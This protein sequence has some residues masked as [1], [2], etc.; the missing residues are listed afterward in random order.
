MHFMTFNEAYDMIMNNEEIEY[1]RRDLNFSDNERREVRN[2]YKEAIRGNKNYYFYGEP[3]KCLLAFKKMDSFFLVTELYVY[4]QY[5]RNG[6]A[7]EL[8][9]RIFEMF[10]YMDFHVHVN[11]LNFRGIQAYKKAGF[12]YSDTVDDRIRFSILRFVRLAG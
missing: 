10:G 7:T 5:R 6:C 1:F 11:S 4:E 3:N 12:V 2:Y 8:F 9:K